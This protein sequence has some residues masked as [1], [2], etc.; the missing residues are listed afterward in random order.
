MQTFAQYVMELYGKSVYQI[1]LEV[2]G[3]YFV[4]HPAATA[5]EAWRQAETFLKE[6]EKRWIKAQPEAKAQS[7]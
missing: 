2:A 5:E 4:Y 6:M 3:T 7:A 1:E